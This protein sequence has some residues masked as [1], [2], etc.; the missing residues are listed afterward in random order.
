VSPL[1][2]K[3]TGFDAGAYLER[4]EDAA[5]FSPAGKVQ[6]SLG[7]VFE[8]HLPGA[9]VGSLCRIETS[10]VPGAPVVQAEVIGFRDK[11]VLL[12]PFDDATGISNLSRIRLEQE[13]SSILVGE[14]LLGRVLDARGNP[15]DGKGPLFDPGEGEWRGLYQKPSHP[16]ER[17]VIRKP[18]DLGVRAINALLT[19]GRGQRVGIMAGS[20]VGKSVLLGM[21]ARHTAADVNVIALIGERGREVRE[22]IERDLGPEGLARSVVIVATSDQSP[23]LRM[24]GAFL[25]STIA[26]YFRDQRQDVLLMMDSVT[27][28]C[29]AQRE[30]GLSMGEP[31]ASKGYTP[32]VFATLPKLLE[33][34]GTGI[35]GGSITGLF[36]VLVEGDDMD[37]PIA[38]SARS[39]LDG[40]IVLSRKIAQR[41]HF[42][43]ID[44]LQSASRVMRSVISQDHLEF[45]GRIREWMA[46]YQQIEDLLNLGAYQKGSNPRIDTAILVH[47]RIDQLLRQ[48]IDDGASLDETIAAMRSIVLAAEAASSP[49]S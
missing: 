8:A 10:Q 23:L 18:L 38:D 3:P 41:N 16:L 29:M 6:K 42:P 36:T 15:I 9:K 2:L 22:F 35:G 11:R 1:E 19:C 34:A 4:L 26:E 49:S 31:P 5:L 39:I 14:K 46:T 24:R 7:M 17:E 44:V 12:M 20:G 45:S 21:M 27:R 47:D 28:F 40:H 13:S 32:S 33:R 25:A 30:I 43:A 37:D 48:G